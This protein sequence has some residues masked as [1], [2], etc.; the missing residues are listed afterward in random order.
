[1]AMWYMKLVI[2]NSYNVVSSIQTRELSLGECT[3]FKK[4]Y[5]G[6]NYYGQ[7]GNENRNW[8][9]HTSSSSFVRCLTFLVDDLAYAY[10]FPFLIPLYIKHFLKVGKKVAES[11]FFNVNIC[12]R[13]I[14]KVF[15][16]PSSCWSSAFQ[17]K[18][19]FCRFCETN[20]IS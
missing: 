9:W 12:E 11:R 8:F 20:P 1:M 19:T 18:F 4:L 15:F 17:F 7:L 10:F 14:A 6:C 13:L 3:K 16:S 2:I 5:D